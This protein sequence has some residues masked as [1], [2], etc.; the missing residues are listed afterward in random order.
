MK[1]IVLLA[2][3]LMMGAGASAKSV[4]MS[5]VMTK[6]T[7]IMLNNVGPNV[8]FTKG[9]TDNY[10]LTL[11]G[12]TGSLVMSVQSVGSDGV[13][14]DTKIDIAGQS[15][16]EQE[17]INPATGQ[18]IKVIVNGQEQAPPDPNDVQIIS[19]TSATVTVPAGTFKT[20]DVKAHIKSQNTDMEQ[21]V[22]PTD[23][24]VAGMVKMATTVQSIPLTAE[25]TKVTHGTGQ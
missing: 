11:E 2:A 14:L 19:E 10:N 15:Q 25:L 13:W 21:W 16:D 8:Q 23:V 6:V 1:R 22:D 18:V 5:S 20:I 12:I 9:D 7:H 17:L 4:N 24:L 3:C